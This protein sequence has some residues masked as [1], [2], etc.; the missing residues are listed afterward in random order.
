MDDFNFYKNLFDRELSRRNDLDN[1]INLPLNTLIICAGL[2]YFLITKIVEINSNITIYIIYII[3][4]FATIFLIKS[5]YYLIMSYNN[6]F[7]GFDY[8]QFPSTR[9]LRDYQF[10]LQKFDKIQTEQNNSFERPIGNEILLSFKV[11]NRR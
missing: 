1:A 9:K 8:L 7:K 6:L 3:I 10:E 2:I 11:K 4:V 5:I